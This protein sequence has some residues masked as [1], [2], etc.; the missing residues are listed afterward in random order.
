MGSELEPTTFGFLDLPERNVDALLIRPPQLVFVPGWGI[1]A[2]ESAHTR[3]TSLH[4]ADILSTT[5]V[6]SG[7]AGL[8]IV[9]GLVL[10]L[11][12]GVVVWC[13][14]GVVVWQYGGV[15]M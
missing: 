2:E 4:Q 7:L 9:V 15:V 6:A 10:W 1:G 8:A 12:D 14:Y 11:Y 13:C 5:S 3:P